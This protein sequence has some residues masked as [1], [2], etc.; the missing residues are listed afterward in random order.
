[1]NERQVSRER[2]V[3]GLD[4]ASVT[5]W[6]RDWVAS[7]WDTYGLIDVRPQAGDEPEGVRYARMAEEVHVLVDDWVPHAVF[8]ERTYSRGKRTAEVL[9]GLTAITLA[10]LE[11]RGIEYAFVDATTL[12]KFAT[13]SG[14]ADK[15]AMIDAAREAT[16]LTLPH[17]IADAYWLTRYGREVLMRTAA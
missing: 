14:N 5:G 13:G 1:M 9:N 11:R 17:D 8:I 6:Y 15:Q 10:V 12:K 3:L 7:G 4:I 2:T 16:G